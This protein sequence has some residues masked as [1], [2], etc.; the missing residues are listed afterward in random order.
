[1]KKHLPLLFGLLILIFPSWSTILNA[2]QKTSAVPSII[3]LLLLTDAGSP[4]AFIKSDPPNGSTNLPTSPTLSW[5]ASSGATSYEYCFD[6]ANDNGCSGWTSVGTTTSVSLS[7][8][9]NNTS[10]YWQVRAKNASGT[11]YSNGG[12]FWSFTTRQKFVA[13]F[14]ATGDAT[15]DD[16]QPYSNFGAD[17]FLYV[18]MTITSI[19]RSV[20]MFDVSGIPA[21]N[22]VLSAKVKVYVNACGVG[23]GPAYLAAYKVKTAWYKL[24]VTWNTPWTIP[25]G[26]F[27][28]TVVST[29]PI[30]QTDVGTWKE[31]D[32][33]P[34]VQVW[35]ANPAYNNGV[36]LQLINQT[37]VTQYQLSSS[38]NSV[39]AWAPVL[40][41]EYGV[42]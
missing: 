36:M 20:L 10:Y 22:P 9:S 4:G 1:M 42:P 28:A 15:I 29:T 30:V 12:T 21:V 39:P 37:N 40:T 27:D 2:A 5:E 16:G 33:T 23:G 31:L 7:G 24:T 13:A 14:V 41:V 6:T 8:L 35:V 19:T 34:W 3:P 18:G 26:D 11:T 38:E 17:E 25:G 32:I